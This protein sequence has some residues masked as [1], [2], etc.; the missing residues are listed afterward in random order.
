MITASTACPP[1]NHPG[2]QKILGI[3]D[4]RLEIYSRLKEPQLANYFAPHG[5]IFI[6]ESPMV[7]LRALDAGYHPLSLLVEEQQFEATE[8]GKVLA[9]CQSIP[10]YVGS[11]PVLSQITGFPLTRGVLCAM[12]RNPLPTPGEVCRNARRI[13]V[14]EDV[15]NPTNVG[16]IFRNAAALHMDAVLLTPNC[17]DPLYRRA[18][19]VSMGSVFQLPWTFLEETGSSFQSV[20]QHLHALGYSCA[21][22][23]LSPQAVSLCDPRL[24]AEKK[25]AVLLGS[26]ATGLSQATLKDCDYILRIPMS[27]GVDSLNVAAA[28]AIAFWELGTKEEGDSPA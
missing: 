8:V 17:S 23:A 11:L 13:A 28:S 3:E 25:L 7:I 20:P 18:L 16:A 4:P 21:A 1:Q 14:L 12:K 27:H 5:G 15:M 2:I 22:M 6:A 9:Q 10:I 26:E 24:S 19:R